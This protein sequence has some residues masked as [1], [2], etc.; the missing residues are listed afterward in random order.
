MRVP[1]DI[2]TPFAVSNVHADHF[3][4]FIEEGE[5]GSSGVQEV[6]RHLLRAVD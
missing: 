6:L 3:E 2:A 4:P 5:A 1:A